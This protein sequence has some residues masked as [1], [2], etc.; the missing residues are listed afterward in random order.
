MIFAMIYLRALAFPETFNFFD[1]FIVA[2]E[3]AIPKSVAILVIF[4][5][6]KP[7]TPQS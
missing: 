3:P 7:V 2:V 1:S 4:S 6:S 5:L